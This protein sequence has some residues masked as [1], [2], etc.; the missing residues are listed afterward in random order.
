MEENMDKQI[1]FIEQRLKEYKEQLSRRKEVFSVMVQ[2][3]IDTGCFE[4]NAIS[5][6]NLMM[7]I[8]AAI[9]E[10]EFSLRCLKNLCQ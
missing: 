1:E 9:K 2:N 3:E 6:L 8:K 5:E 7:E 4:K 10:L